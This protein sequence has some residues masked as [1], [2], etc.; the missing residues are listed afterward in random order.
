MPT[1]LTPAIT[2]RLALAPDRLRAALAALVQ[3]NYAAAVH[4]FQSLASLD[5]LL[6]LRGVRTVEIPES[7]DLIL[8][9]AAP[10]A[11]LARHWQAA[12][13]GRP[14]TPSAAE[15][16]PDRGYE[17]AGQGAARLVTPSR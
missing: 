11:R 14:A 7:T 15:P 13:T 2:Q 16:R 12:S 8:E 9:V 6:A 4:H 3:A 10:L 5:T 17:A 1:P